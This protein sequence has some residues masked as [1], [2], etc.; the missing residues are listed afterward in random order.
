MSARCNAELA[1]L[2]TCEGSN[3]FPVERV[4]AVRVTCETTAAEEGVSE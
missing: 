3:C 1:K 2:K 4:H